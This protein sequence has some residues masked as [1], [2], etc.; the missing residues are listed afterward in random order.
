MSYLATPSSAFS[1]TG[2]YTS[3]IKFSSENTQPWN[4]EREAA[5]KWSAAFDFTGI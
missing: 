4:K 5:G 3:V 2:F 1:I